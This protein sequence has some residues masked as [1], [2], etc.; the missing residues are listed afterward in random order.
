[1]IN[2]AKQ[3][4]VIWVVFENY[5]G[6]FLVAEIN[7]QVDII[8]F[9]GVWF[10]RQLHKRDYFFA[11][12]NKIPDMFNN[13]SLNIIQITKNGFLFGIFLEQFIYRMINCQFSDFTVEGLQ[14][15][16][17]FLTPGGEIF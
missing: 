15:A 12:W 10:L 11:T 13:I 2:T 6:G 17:G 3:V 7:H 5:R 9:K 16:F 14:F 4:A 8:A 1:V